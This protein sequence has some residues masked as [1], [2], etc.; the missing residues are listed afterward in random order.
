MDTAL[1]KSTMSARMPGVG[2]GDHNLVPKKGPALKRE[3]T[4]EPE[5]NRERR[6]TFSL[7]LRIFISHKR[8]RDDQAARDVAA[9]GAHAGK[10]VQI[11]MS[12]RFPAGT[13]WKQKIEAELDKSDW[14]IFLYTDPAAGWEW[15]FYEIG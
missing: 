2:R 11:V 5:Q 8:G 9:I 10:N 6:R 15:C 4:I 12:Q 14:L 1:R 7:P 13:V 3:N